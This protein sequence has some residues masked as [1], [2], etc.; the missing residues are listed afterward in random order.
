ML[1]PDPLAQLGEV[2]AQRLLGDLGTARAEG[3]K[4]DLD[5]P[6]AQVPVVVTGQVDQELDD[7]AAD[8][9][10]AEVA[11]V[12]RSEHVDPQRR[13]SWRLRSFGW[14]CCR[15]GAAT[16][17]W[18]GG[19]MGSTFATAVLGRR[20]TRFARRSGDGGTGQG[21]AVAPTLDEDDDAGATTTRAST[22][23]QIGKP[24]PAEPPPPEPELEPVP[25]AAAR[26]VAGS[27]APTQGGVFWAGGAAGTAGKLMRG[28]RRRGDGD[29]HGV[30]AAR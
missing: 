11:E 1:G 19:A 10:G 8:V 26:P 13:A 9:V 23:A 29:R 28:A 7:D 30:P 18:I 25:E 22:A 21:T 17:G 6:D 20:S 12:E 14:W 3:A 27:G 24:P 2:V 4:A 15:S 16:T 5:L